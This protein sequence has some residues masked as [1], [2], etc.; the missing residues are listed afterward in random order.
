MR[1]SEVG[2]LAYKA[3]SSKSK[4]CADALSALVQYLLKHIAFPCILS[5]SILCLVLVSVLSCKG[6][7]WSN[8]SLSGRPFATST[9]LTRRWPQLRGK[10]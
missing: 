2:L 7:Q 9:V 8:K 5:L 10:V 4:T 1:R 6:G 3:S